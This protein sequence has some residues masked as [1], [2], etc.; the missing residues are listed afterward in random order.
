MQHGGANG[1]I[2]SEGMHIQNFII[3][4]EITSSQRAKNK[5]SVVVVVDKN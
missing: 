2:N 3:N 1:L 4:L 5:G